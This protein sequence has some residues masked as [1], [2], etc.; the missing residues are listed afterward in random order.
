M[1]ERI[2]IANAERYRLILGF[3][4]SFVVVS[5]VFRIPWT[6]DTIQ[7]EMESIHE[8]LYLG[9][10]TFFISTFVGGFVARTSF[11]AAALL[12]SLAV[13]VVSDSFYDRWVEFYPCGTSFINS[14]LVDSLIH[15]FAT[16]AAV[17]GG[18]LGQKTSRLFFEIDCWRVQ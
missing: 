4:V 18:F 12:F 10:A 14:S 8:M 15:I 11:A 5:I 9:V 7:G 17:V 16:I 3:A 2:A 6:I 1:V 13:W